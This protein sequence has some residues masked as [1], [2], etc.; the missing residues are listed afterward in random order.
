MTLA[1]LYQEEQARLAAIAAARKTV[2]D[3]L[4]AY[5]RARDRLAYHTRKNA[6]EPALAAARDEA[7]HT[8]LAWQKAR[9]ALLR[10]I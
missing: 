9:R 6:P 4:S 8:R 2:D 3:A 5:H 7:H 1:E 10:A